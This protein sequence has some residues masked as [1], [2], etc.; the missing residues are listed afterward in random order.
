MS[1]SSTKPRASGVRTQDLSDNQLLGHHATRQ[2]K[3][4]IVA[5]S[6][7]KKHFP[8]MACG[9]SKLSCAFALLLE[10]DYQNI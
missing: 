8:H 9:F 6:K 3:R 2:E 10:A 4:I 1:C 7:R 5:I